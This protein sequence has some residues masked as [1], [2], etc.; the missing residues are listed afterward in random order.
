MPTHFL[1]RLIWID[2][3]AM[4]PTL[5]LS[6]GHLRGGEVV[7]TVAG[8]F[9]GVGSDRCCTAAVQ[10]DGVQVVC[11][12]FWSEIK[13]CGPDDLVKLDRGHVGA[14]NQAQVHQIVAKRDAEAKQR[15]GRVRDLQFVASNQTGAK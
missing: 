10:R 5:S 3:A 1:F 12:R 4:R 9:E 2:A 7:D 11:G 15:E 13:H 14:L 8:T 6:T